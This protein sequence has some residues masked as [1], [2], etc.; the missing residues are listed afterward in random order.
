MGDDLARGHLGT[1]SLSNIGGDFVH[2]KSADALRR[3]QKPGNLPPL[4]KDALDVV[5]AFY[6]LIWRTGSPTRTVL[7]GRRL[8]RQS[9]ATHRK[10]L[11]AVFGGDDA[12][13]K[14]FDDQLIMFDE[15]VD[16]ILVEDDLF[17]FQPT[18]FEDAFVSSA[19]LRAAVARYARTVSAKVPITNLD[20]FQKRCEDVPSMQ[21][22]LARIAESPTFL[23]WKPSIAKLQAYSKKYGTRSK[24]VVDFVGGKMVFDGSLERQWNILK[25]LDQ[26]FFTGELTSTKFEATGKH[27][28]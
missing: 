8:A 18:R 21:L 28:V 10:G 7:L 11:A 3:L 5:P 25:L 9:V 6:V 17:V 23:A 27:T 26:A 20:D 22:R 12:T 13:L 16:W 4:R 14:K 2:P 1:L 24:P 19:A 15:D